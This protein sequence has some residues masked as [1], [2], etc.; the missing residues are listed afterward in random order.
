VVGLPIEVIDAGDEDPI[1]T[2]GRAQVHLAAP[3]QLLTNPVHGGS[4]IEAQGWGVVMTS[5]NRP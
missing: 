5:V 1:G 3:G 2:A 4:V